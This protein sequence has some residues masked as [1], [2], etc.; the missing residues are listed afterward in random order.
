VG[1]QVIQ[2]N[3]AFLSLRVQPGDALKMPGEFNFTPLV[4]NEI[5]SNVVE[6]IFSY[7]DVSPLEMPAS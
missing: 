3:G 2:D 4:E 7:P 5:V 6:V 1:V